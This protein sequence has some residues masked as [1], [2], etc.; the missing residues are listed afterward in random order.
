M[1]CGSAGMEHTA[2][3]NKVA[4]WPQD[5]YLADDIIQTNKVFTNFNR[6]LQT[7]PGGLNKVSGCAANLPNAQRFIQVSMETTVVHSNVN[8]EEKLKLVNSLLHI[9]KETIMP[10]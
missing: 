3:V 1:L 7:L 6:L 8:C 9:H 4:M 10:K 2:R 5:N